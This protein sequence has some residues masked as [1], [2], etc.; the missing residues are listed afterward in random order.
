MKNEKELTNKF[1]YFIRKSKTLPDFMQDSYV[2]EFKIL[3][4]N[5]L[6]FNSD[7]RPTQIPC[8]LQA[9]LDCLYYKISDQSVG[10]KPFDAFN[11][12][13]VNAYLA[14]WIDKLYLIDVEQI[15]NLMKTNKSI[16]QKEIKCLADYII[17]LKI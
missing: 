8:L 13:G 11:I 3:K 15:N 6:N 5:R 9:K 7:L 1:N 2:I 4:K 10:A 17:D 16:S 12:C 14:I